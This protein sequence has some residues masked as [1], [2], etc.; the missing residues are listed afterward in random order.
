MVVEDLPSA[1][2]WR[3]RWRQCRM[4]VWNVTL[5]FLAVMTAFML[6][7]LSSAC[8]SQESMAFIRSVA[9]SFWLLNI[10]APCWNCQMH[11]SFF[12]TTTVKSLMHLQCLKFAVGTNQEHE[13]TLSLMLC[14]SSSEILSL[15]GVWHCAVWCFWKCTWIACSSSSDTLHIYA[16]SG[17]DWTSIPRTDCTWRPEATDEG[18]AHWAWKFLAAVNLL[19]S[20]A[21]VVI[22]HFIRVCCTGI[23]A[24]YSSSNIDNC[25]NFLYSLEPW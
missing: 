20:W 11:F 21:R 5:S 18:H 7:S 22:L 23:P 12:H 25:W 8:L 2:L 14:L 16:P 4:S 9:P 3:K 6:V 24:D 1:I 10:Y 13:F 19:W 15:T 17:V